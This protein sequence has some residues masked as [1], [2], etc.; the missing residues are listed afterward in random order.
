MKGKTISFAF[1]FCILFLGS[2]AISFAQGTTSRVTGTITDSSGA[3]VSGA[4]VT[5]INEG[6]KVS[7]TAVTSDS[8][9][10]VFDLV[11]PGIYTVTIEKE[12]FKKFVTPNNSVLVNQPATVNVALEVGG[13]SEVVTVEGAVEQV[14]TSTS[15]NVG[16]TITQREVESL[17]IVAA[18]GR[19]P[20]DLLN[21][22]PGIVNGANTGGGVHVHGS[23]DR[24]FNFTLDGIDINE[25]SAGGSNFTPLRPNPDSIQEFQVVTSNF[26][27]ELGRSSGAQVTFV[28]RS[29]TN[30]LTGNLFEYYQTPGLLANSYANNTLGV[31]R[32]KFI[33][34]IFGGSVGGPVVIPGFGE[35][36]PSLHVLKDKVFFFVNLQLLRQ[37]QAQLAQRTV[38]T[39]A[40]RQGIFRYVRG[41]RNAPFGTATSTNFPTGAAVDANGNP[42]YANCGA[43]GTNPCIAT[44]NIGNNPSGIGIDPTILRSI[45]LAPLPN[46]FTRGDGL[47]TAGYN[48]LAPTTERQYDFV[49]KFDFKV[50][51][52]NQFY[53]RYA[54]GEQNTIS[55]S[56]NSGLAPFPGLPGIVDTFR[57]PKNLAI[58][59]R[60]SPVASIVNEFIYGYSKFTFFFGTEENTVPF[61][62]N[63]VT[64]AGTNIRGN[65][66][67][68]RTHQ[69]VDNLTWIKGNHLVKTGINFRF[70]RHID[71]R[72]EVAGGRIEGRVGFERTINDNFN[73]FNLPTASSTSINTNDLNTIRSQ[74]NDF[75]GRV[76]SYTQAFVSN[77]D[78]TAF[79]PA[80][81][82]WN[83]TANYAE[84][85]FYVQDTWKFRPN[86]TLDFGVR[87]EPKFSPTSDGLPILR[88]DQPV[89]LGAPPS[90]TIR[91]VESELFKTDWNN[92][93]PSVGFA[94]DPFKKGKTSIRANYRLSYDRFGT[95]L[96][97]QAIYQNAP[98]NNI[99]FPSNNAFG[100]GGGLFRNLPVLVPTRTP[101]QERQ[102]T[103]FG[104]LSQQTIAPDLVFP[105]IHQWYAGFQHELPLSTVLEVNYIGKRGLHL[106]GGYDSNQVKLNDNGFLNAFIELRNNRSNAAYQSTYFN[107]LL[108]GD[109]R[110]TTTGTNPDGTATRML[111]RV[112]GSEIATGSV[113]SVAGNLATG[114]GGRVW[115]TNTGNPFFFQNFPQFSTALNVVDSNDVSKYHGLELILKR[116]FAQGVSFQFGYTLSK[117]MDTR[118]FD[119]VFLSGNQ[120]VFKG[121]GQAASSTPFDNNNRR[122]NYA[123]SDFDRRHAFQATYVVEFPVGD[124]RKF[125]SDIPL[126]LDWII[127]GW[128]LA[129]TFNLA[130]GRPFT[131]YS[132]ANTLSNVVATPANCN[133]C[134]R[135]LG[136]VIQFLGTNYY[137]TAEQQ[138]LFSTP[139]PGEFGNTGRNYFIGPRQFQTDASLSKKFKLTERF[140]FDLRI[141]ARNL[142]NTPSF[143]APNAILN[144]TTPFGR[145]RESV[146]SEARRVQVS[147]KFNF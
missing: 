122:L 124:G 115:Q 8:G 110:I 67:G 10:Y 16:S 41:G 126:P 86:L 56:G 30:R 142:T 54:Q 91:W 15:G 71:D 50:N 49:S 131:V 51:E 17:P 81:T 128:Q 90:N 37:T 1:A 20:L 85:D 109:T 53:V 141:D 14:Q 94:W 64:D 69:F 23:R 25:S 113:A 101:F 97:A 3:A 59:Y 132:D 77:A 73:A 60:W 76:G 116:K 74:I 82:R 31:R 27:A 107:A 99:L 84:Y 65:G 129:G 103:A 58:N 144:S 38:Y 70:N 147:G 125:L 87:W 2:A 39:E 75:L 26:T 47:N 112:Y 24:S 96:F 111:L 7:L 95:Q 18:R 11:Q 33:Q 61:V 138:A 123:F 4:T 62:L 21:Y 5:L 130:S 143:A 98:G 78:G 120:I 12:G 100:Q 63:L 139:A 93:S 22:Q 35:G 145:I 68:V 19:N 13:V 32:P 34:H 117:S 36:T 9:A 146:V 45:N 114:V 44:Y 55:D 52:K 127:G 46:D 29:G 88:P 137:F 72:S 133:G 89:T 43:S 140:S 118:S 105:E 42:V 102:P 6:T 66:R 136:S 134:S 106:I 80:G 119:P 57:K 83:F 108:A 121:N 104:T 79:A 28:T 40:A 135:N 48:F 92:F